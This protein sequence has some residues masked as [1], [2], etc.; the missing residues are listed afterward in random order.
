MNTVNYATQTN[1]M[2]GSDIFKLTPFFLQQVSIPGISF[3]HPEVGGGRF[4]SVGTLN[5]DTIN[6]GDLTIEI[7]M[8]ESFLVYDE[9]MGVINKQIDI[10]TGKFTQKTFDFWVTVTDSFGNEL[11]KWTYH[12]AKIES[13][14]D[15]Q[16]DYS[17]EETM[18][19]LSVTLK[20]DRFE[21]VHFKSPTTRPTLK[22]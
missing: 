6:Y 7:I 1:V 20:F 11:I 17:S 4:G 13:I 19:T 15:F 12:N 14:S 21:Y 22:L 5:A 18:F 10:V 2:A 16:Y 8:D 9:I 3:S